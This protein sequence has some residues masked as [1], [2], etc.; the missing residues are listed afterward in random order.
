MKK[1]ASLILAVL[2]LATTFGHVSAAPAKP[3]LVVT[4]PSE[5]FQGD[6]FVFTV[7]VTGLPKARLTKVNYQ[8]KIYKQAV[9]KAW[10]ATLNSQGASFK[11]AGDHYLITWTKAVKKNAK[12]TFAAFEVGIKLSSVNSGLKTLLQTIDGKSVVT[13]PVNIKQAVISWTV[14]APTVVKVGS[15]YTITISAYNPGNAVLPVNVEFEYWFTCS[16]NNPQITFPEGF[17]P[18]FDVNYSRHKTT[19]TGS[20]APHSTLLWTYRLIAKP[21]ANLHCGVFL[22]R[23]LTKSYEEIKYIDF[24]N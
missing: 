18:Y 20:V 15:A 21:Y 4:P 1:L 24:V 3:V 23:D 17:N 14:S 13:S 10:I 16:S 9:D 11:D 19:W 22:F 6:E 2:I 7:M 5:G 8:I 12:D